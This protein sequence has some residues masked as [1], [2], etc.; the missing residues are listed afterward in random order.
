MKKLFLFALFLVIS[1]VGTGC[2]SVTVDGDEEAVL[3]K[4]P[5]IFGSGGVDETPVEPGQTWTALTTHEVIFKTTPVTYKETFDDL[6]TDDNTPVD[7]DLYVELQ[8]VKGKTPE[9]YK[10]FGVDWYQNNIAP[11][12]RQ[13]VRDKASQYKMFDLAGNREVLTNV[14]KYVFDNLAEH[15]KKKGISVM[16]NRAIMGK[17]TPPAQVLEETERTAAQ[18]QS[19]LTQAARAKAED[20]RKDAEVK[21]AIAD[22]AYKNQMNMTI[23]QYMELR[24]LEIEKEKVELLKKN[25]NATIIFGGLPTTYSVNKK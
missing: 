17:V 21:K 8:V 16:L 10:A 4:Q 7:L 1:F 6:I 22:N 20:A 13:L 3:V 25:P 11:T 19:V 23:D 12:I 9:L 24:G 14:E 15:M 5:W 2:N 18:N